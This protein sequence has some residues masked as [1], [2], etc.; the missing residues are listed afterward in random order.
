VLGYSLAARGERNVHLLLGAD[1]RYVLG[2]FLY[3]L[4]N[5]AGAS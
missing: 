1:H 3:F 2:F 5:H 4:V